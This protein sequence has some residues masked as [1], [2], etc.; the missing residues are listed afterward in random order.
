MAVG[1]FVF[2]STGA[3][4]IAAAKQVLAQITGVILER[5]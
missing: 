1:R 2:R 4:D 3:K 5:R